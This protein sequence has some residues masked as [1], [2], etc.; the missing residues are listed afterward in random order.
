MDKAARLRLLFEDDD[1]LL[2]SDTGLQPPAQAVE[3][4]HQGQPVTTQTESSSAEENALGQAGRPSPLHSDYCAVSANDMAEVDGS[5][6][7][8]NQAADHQ[9]KDTVNNSC[10]KAPV[11]TK[12]YANMRN[13]PEPGTSPDSFSQC[14]CPLLAI[15]RLPYRYIHGELSGYI[16]SRFFDQGK[17]WQRRWDL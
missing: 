1:F 12:Q 6:S 9:A 11:K 14:F 10:E 5:I 2:N 15:S 3:P 8:G 17:F 16:A 13:S 7:T 4:V